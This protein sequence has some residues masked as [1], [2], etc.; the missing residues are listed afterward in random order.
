MVQFTQDGLSIYYG[1]PDAPAP[2][3]DE[4]CGR[5]GVSVTVAL[6]PANPSNTVTIRYRV[7]GGPVSQLRAVRQPSDGLGNVEYF[8]ATFPDF[9]QGEQ[10]EYLPVGSCAGRTVPGPEIAT[11]FP[12]S[13]RLGSEQTAARPSTDKVSDSIR[14]SWENEPRKPFSLEYLASMR[15][16][17]QKPEII[18]PT[19]EGLRLNWFWYPKEGSVRGPVLNAKVRLLGGDWMTVRRDGIGVMDVRATLQTDDGAMLYVAYPG[20]FELGEDG[21]EKALAGKWP[22]KATT[23]TTPRFHVADP[24]Y[25][26]LNR[27]PCLGIGEVNMHELA[28]EYDIYAVR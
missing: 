26:W 17:L 24:R 27:L 15:I 16:P 21:Y 14:E 11:T 18:G 25:L 20:Y 22:D 23:R 13:F 19:P 28:Y 6:K 4:C 10:V 5:R 3:K 9:W 8:H 1:T 12:S 2:V 7:D